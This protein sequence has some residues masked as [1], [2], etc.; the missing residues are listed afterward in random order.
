MIKYNNLLLFNQ[1]KII[2]K[3]FLHQLIQKENYSKNKLVNLSLMMKN[4][5]LLLFNQ[6]RIILKI[7]LHQLIQKENY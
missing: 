7:F 3:I 1:I 6:I 4:N 5:N 2:L